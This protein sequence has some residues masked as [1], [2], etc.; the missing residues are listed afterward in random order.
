MGC[1]ERFDGIVPVAGERTFATNRSGR[2]SDDTDIRVEVN[3][4]VAAISLDRPPLNIM[5][6]AMMEKLHSAIIGL[7]GRCDV[8]IFRGAG[9]RAFSA[10]AEIADH[11]PDRVGDMLRAFHSVFVELWRS[12]MVTIAAVHGHCLGGG[13][14]LATFCDFVIAAESATFGQPEIKLGCFPPVAMVTFPRLIGMRSSLDLILSGRTIS[15]SEAHRIGLVTRVVTLDGLDQAVAVLVRDLRALSPSVLAMARRS[16][17]NSDGFDFERS[18]QSIEEFYL[19]ELMKTYDAN[20]GIRAFLEKRQP[21][22][23]SA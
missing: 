18:L 7:A 19:K 1:S 6:I 23:Q 8:L 20:E 13:C 5:N 14:E 21:V 3:Q 22:W 11:A 2:V 16:L 17:W 4:R 12:K 15:A 9:E 10:G